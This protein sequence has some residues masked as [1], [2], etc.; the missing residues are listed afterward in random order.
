MYLRGFF[1]LEPYIFLPLVDDKRCK[2]K[3]KTYWYVTFNLSKLFLQTDFL[4]REEF[5]R[6]YKIDRDAIPFEVLFLTN[7]KYTTKHLT[8]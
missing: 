1:K 6:I 7:K 3:K 4:P 8:R 2:K 5:E